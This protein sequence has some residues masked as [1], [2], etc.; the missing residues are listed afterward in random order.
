[1]IK[2]EKGTKEDVNSRYTMR[3]L[4][5]LEFTTSIMKRSVILFLLACICVAI[6]CAAH[7][8]MKNVPERNVSHAAD[9]PLTPVMRH[10][11]LDRSYW[12]LAHTFHQRGGKRRNRGCNHGQFQEQPCSGADRQER[13]PSNTPAAKHDA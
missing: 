9:T 8:V 1:M 7:T 2:S 11:Q 10:P 13:D 4:V 3:A 12:G 5:C 6:S